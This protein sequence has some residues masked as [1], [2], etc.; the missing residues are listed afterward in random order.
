LTLISPLVAAQ[1][2]SDRVPNSRKPT[3]PCIPDA[4]RFDP[5]APESIIPAQENTLSMPDAVRTAVGIRHLSRVV[6]AYDGGAVFNCGVFHPTGYCAM[7]SSSRATIIRREPFSRTFRSGG[8][9][10]YCHVCRYLLVDL[11]DPSLHGKFDNAY[12]PLYVEGP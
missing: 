10:E 12:T 1:L 4:E 3:I 2:I 5:D 7:K 6:G 11:I 9:T 8:T